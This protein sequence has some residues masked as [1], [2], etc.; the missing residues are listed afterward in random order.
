MAPIRSY[1]IAGTLHI[2][3]WLPIQSVLPLVEMAWSEKPSNSGELDKPVDAIG[4]QKLNFEIL[5]GSAELTLGMVSK[6]RVGDVIRLDKDLQAPLFL[7][8]DKSPVRF[9]GYLGKQHDHFA[10]RIDSI[11]K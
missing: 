11:Q 1:W 10:F 6:L 5:L 7:I 9:S 4:G 8:F 3:G 2:N